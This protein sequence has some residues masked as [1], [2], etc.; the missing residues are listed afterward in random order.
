MI[1]PKEG[2]FHKRSH[3]ANTL[4]HRFKLAHKPFSWSDCLF[5]DSFIGK[6]I[7]TWSGKNSTQQIRYLS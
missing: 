1:F 2:L 6:I 7:Y 5:I 4:Q 3:K